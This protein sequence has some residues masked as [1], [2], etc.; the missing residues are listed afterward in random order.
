MWTIARS[1]FF[2]VAFELSAYFLFHIFLATQRTPLRYLSSLS[3]LLSSTRLCSPSPTHVDNLFS[4][5]SILKRRL[6]TLLPLL[7]EVA[8]DVSTDS[9]V[10]TEDDTDADGPPAAVC[11]YGVCMLDATTAT[12]SLGQ[13]ADDPARSRLRTLLAQQLPVEIVM[14]KVRPSLNILKYVCMCPFGIL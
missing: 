5:S 4:F 1:R 6:D 12:F 7:Q 8:L 14:E 2:L 11:E 3:L 13:F 9:G 10:P